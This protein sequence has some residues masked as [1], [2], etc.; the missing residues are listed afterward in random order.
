MFRGHN[1]IGTPG[2]KQS[3]HLCEV[4]VGHVDDLFFL[5]DVIVS[6]PTVTVVYYIVAVVTYMVVLVMYVAVVCV[7]IVPGV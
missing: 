2:Q 4:G 3:L 6:V 7:D 5:C 1:K